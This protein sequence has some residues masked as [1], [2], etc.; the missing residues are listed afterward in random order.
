MTLP[1]ARPN[2]FLAG[3]RERPA[4]CRWGLWCSIPSPVTNELCAGAGFDWLLVDMEHSPAGLQDVYSALQAA[5]AYPVSPVVRPP[6]NDPTWIKRL[7]DIGVRNLLVPFVQS[8]DEARAAVAAATYPPGGMRG[9]TLT[10][11]AN[12]FGRDAGYIGDGVRQIAVVAQIETRAAL[13]RLEEIA[14]VEGLAAVFLGPS[15][16]S[17]DFG[18]LGQPQAPEVQDAIADAAARLARIGKPWGILAGSVEGAHAHARQG[19][20]FVAA[21]SDL[22]LLRA[23]ADGL[24]ARLRAPATPG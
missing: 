15:D 7:L 12:A 18:H 20:S 21:G 8:A 6:V 11:R 3:L 13:D 14:A 23:A 1:T 22:G 5:S 4:R 10:S 2:D 16:L 9:L 24:S 19:A 17:A